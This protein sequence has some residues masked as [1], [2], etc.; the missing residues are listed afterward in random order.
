MTPEQCRQARGLL[1]WTWMTLGVRAG[2]SPDTVKSFETGLHQTTSR[3]HRMILAAFEVAG[4]EFSAPDGY[5]AG[6][7][8]RKQDPKFGDRP[9]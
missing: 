8:V 5:Q 4:V 6:V 3:C 7:R 9:Q 1:G 2:C